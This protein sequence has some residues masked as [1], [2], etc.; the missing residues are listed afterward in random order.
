MTGGEQLRA[1]AERSPATQ[2]WA[3]VDLVAFLILLH[4]CVTAAHFTLLLSGTMSARG[5][6]QSLVEFAIADTAATIVP[7]VVAAL[8]LFWRRWWGW[9][10]RGGSRPRARA[11]FSPSWWTTEAI[12]KR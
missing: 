4:A 5:S 11:T 3:A 8:G 12:P 9:S 2:R 1:D 6:Y 10:T 7:S